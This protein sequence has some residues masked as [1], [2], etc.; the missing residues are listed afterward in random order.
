MMMA[1]AVAAAATMMVVAMTAVPLMTALAAGP[2]AKPAAAALTLAA[3]R[4][5]T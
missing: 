4:V 5:A 2:V 3:P 1:A